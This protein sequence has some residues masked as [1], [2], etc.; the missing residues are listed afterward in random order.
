MEINS[1]ATPLVTEATS[2]PP[3]VIETPTV[4]PDGL[5]PDLRAI[6][7][8]E[9]RKTGDKVPDR[10]AQLAVLQNYYDRSFV[11]HFR[12]LAGLMRSG[13][14]SVQAFAALDQSLKNLSA[15]RERLFGEIMGKQVNSTP[16]GKPSPATT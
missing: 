1:T 13:A 7:G 4:D 5:S 16:T 15:E 6:M 12:D 9:Y 14:D 11:M 10:L 8:I 3:A 2:T